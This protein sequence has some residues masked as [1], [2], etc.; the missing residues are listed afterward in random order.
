MGLFEMTSL[1]VTRRDKGQ[2]M[3]QIPPPDPTG[4]SGED[5]ERDPHRP[6]PPPPGGPSGG[7]DGQAADVGIRLGAKLIDGLLVGFVYAILIT[8]LMVGL[9]FADASVTGG[10]GFGF[11]VGG[12]LTS[13][14][15]AVVFIGY[16]AVM[17]S[18]RGQ[19]V[20][21]MLLN[22]RVEGS[23]GGLPTME[24]AIRRNAW[25]GLSVIPFLGGLAQLAAAIAIAVTISQSMT[26][27]GWHDDFAGGTQV[28]RTG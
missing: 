21:K 22:L 6:P 16:F 1:A 27:Q 2:T 7:G 20:G 11:S 8:P 24:E 12:W 9:L 15:S 18:Y 23:G 13:V 28:V 25:I 3:S 10:F 4:S 19:T 5:H 14:V 17:E 26:K